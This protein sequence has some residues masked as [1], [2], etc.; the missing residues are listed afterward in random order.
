MHK[1]QLRI[2][3]DLNIKL[4]TVKLL[5][6]N[7][8][9]TS[10][11]GFGN[12]FM[13]VISNHRQTGVSWGSRTSS[14]MWMPSIPAALAEGTILPTVLQ[15]HLRHIC[16]VLCVWACVGPLVSFCVLELILPWLIMISWYSQCL[17]EN[18]VLSKLMSSLGSVYFYDNII[19]SWWIFTLKTGR[20]L[21]RIP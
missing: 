16:G 8:E 12:D 19:L 11:H 5:E 13:N 10:W 15:N 20:H 18:C 1:Y 3:K 21:I 9:E 2:D 14:S 6:E 7:T 17:V 4:E